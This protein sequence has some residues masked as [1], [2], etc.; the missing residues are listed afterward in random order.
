MRQIPG[1]RGLTLLFA[2]VGLTAAG[3]STVP[4]LPAAA[5][6]LNEA[7]VRAL[8]AGELSDAEAQLSLATEYSP[9][10]TEAWANLGMLELSRGNLNMAQKHL[11]NALDLN[12]HLP[13]P[14]HGLGLIAERRDKVDVAIKHYRDALQV[15]PGFVASRV[16]LANLLFRGKKYELAREEFHKLVLHRPKEAAGWLGYVET[17][18][19]LGRAGEAERALEQ[20]SSKVGAHPELAL[21][22]ARRMIAHGDLANAEATLDALCTADDPS[23]ASRAFAFAAVVHMTRGDRGRA[24]AALNEA[25]VRDPKSAVALQLATQVR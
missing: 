1:F 4:P 24:K 10:F 14:H 15:D 9:S 11:E 22:R 13:A 3:C 8:A 17:L 16:N 5:R 20:A 25:L 2:W 21:L 18:L 19:R 23:L 7:G 12:E 6:D